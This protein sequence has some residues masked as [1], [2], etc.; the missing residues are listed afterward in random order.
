MG[1]AYR[2]QFNG[3]SIYDMAILLRYI[4]MIQF[5]MNNIAIVLP[6]PS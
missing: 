2:Q 1:V 5:T 4:I 3:I 6:I